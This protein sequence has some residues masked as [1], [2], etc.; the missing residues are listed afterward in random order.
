MDAVRMAD[1]P[2]TDTDG[3]VMGAGPAGLMARRHNSSSASRASS[4][5]V[6]SHQSGQG[7]HRDGQPIGCGGL[8]CKIQPELGRTPVTSAVS[9]PSAPHQPPRRERQG[10]LRLLGPAL[11][12]AEGNR[13]ASPP[14]V[15]DPLPGRR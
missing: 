5:S 13:T 11:H 9:H 7:S 10:T 4:R 8:P 15:T 6:G 1:L 14:P 2:T 12:L 3:L